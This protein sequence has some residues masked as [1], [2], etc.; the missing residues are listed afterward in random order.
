M[1]FANWHLPRTLH[2]TLAL[3]HAHLPLCARLERHAA[4]RRIT[5]Q[6]AAGKERKFGAQSLALGIA[7]LRLTLREDDKQAALALVAT[8]RK[9]L[10]N[11]PGDLDDMSRVRSPH[12]TCAALNRAAVVVQPCQTR[13]LVVLLPVLVAWM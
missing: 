12:A 3:R 8:L 6:Q 1:T 7:V 2:S 11:L 5:L 9:R 10:C 4:V 13:Q